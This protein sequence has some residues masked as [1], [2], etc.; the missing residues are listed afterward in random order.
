MTLPVRPDACI[1][2]GTV[3]PGNR[4]LTSVPNGRSI[5]IDRANGHAWRVCG[6]CAEWELLGPER[7]GALMLELRDRAPSALNDPALHRDQLGQ[8]KLLLMPMDVAAP[9]RSEAGLQL[10]KQLSW[11]QRGSWIIAMLAPIYMIMDIAAS[12][13]TGWFLGL[14]VSIVTLA[15]GWMALTFMYL[16]HNGY[17]ADSL[18][19]WFRPAMIAVMATVVTGYIWLALLFGQGLKLAHFYALY[20]FLPSMMIGDRRKPAGTMFTSFGK[21]LPITQELLDSMVIDANPEDGTLVIRGIPK[22]GNLVGR[23]AARLLELFSIT[24]TEAATP[25]DAEEGW[26][27]LRRHSSLDGLAQALSHLR[28]DDGGGVRWEDLSTTW[29]VALAIGAA[30]AMGSK[31]GTGKLLKKLEEETGVAVIAGTLSPGAD[32]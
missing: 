7:T 25:R 32:R 11:A 22:Y 23:D 5:V 31:I 20:A 1:K 13:L 15:V 12:E 27:L 3:F 6:K 28:P 14:N 29:K 16:R 26:L 9:I 21:S 19:R 17:R 8:V 18:P 10:K 30:E 2:C 24:L 4:D